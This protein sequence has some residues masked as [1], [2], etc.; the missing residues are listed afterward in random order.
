MTRKVRSVEDALK[1]KSPSLGKVQ[2]ERGLEFTEAYVMAWLIEMNE[3]LDLK[4]PMSEIQIRLTAC[5]IVDEFYSL[6]VADLTLVTKM[7][8]SGRYGDFYERLSMTKILTCFR[9]YNEE[10]MMYASEQSARKHYDEKAQN[11]N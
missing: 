11:K 9:E 5:N 2:R 8:M 3:V 1:S 7:I 10:R 6:N 4:N